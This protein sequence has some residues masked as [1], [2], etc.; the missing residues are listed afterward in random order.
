MQE[1]LNKS[2]CRHV[3]VALDA[4]FGGGFLDSIALGSTRSVSGLNKAIPLGELLKRTT[5][6]MTRKLLASGA[7][8]PVFD[9]APEGHSPFATH[10]LEAL[11]TWGGSAGFLRFLDI[12]KPVIETRP[13]GLAERFGQDEAGS[14]FFFIP[15]R[16]YTDAD[17]SK[18][19]K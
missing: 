7:L 5:P 1:L 15:T 11:R 13:F 9:G 3:V 17:S 4:C 8:E 18:K 2:N 6:L 14:D 19:P 10:I 12:A 16:F